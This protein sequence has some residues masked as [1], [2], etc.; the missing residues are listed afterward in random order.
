MLIIGTSYV[1]YS[2]TAQAYDTRPDTHWKQL[3]DKIEYQVRHFPGTPGIYIKD[4]NRGW[5]IEHN[6]DRLFPSA[7]LVKLPVMAA[8]YDAQAQGRLSLDEALP[9]QRRLRAGGSGK[10]KFQKVGTRKTIR[11]LIYH[12]ITESDNTATNILTDYLGLDYFNGYFTRVG[13]GQTNFSRMIMDLRLRNRGIENNTS[14]RDMARIL[15]MLYT[16]NLTGSD[17]MLAIMKDQK[18]NDRLAATIPRSWKICHKTG[19]MNNTC[20]DVG[21]VFSPNSDYIICVLTSGVRNSRR[22]KNFISEISFLTTE[23]Y[24]DSTYQRQEEPSKSLW[25]KFLDITL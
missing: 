16:R 3:Q 17:E 4:L 24:G 23:Y 20:H 9:I 15:E 12:M 22:A 10:L 5:V 1:A 25:S 7:S 18:I 2:S 14:P 6:P 19:L 21:I 8:L 13:L 11:E